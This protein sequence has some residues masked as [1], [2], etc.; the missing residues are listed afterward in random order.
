MLKYSLNVPKNII[1]QTLQETCIH[2][3]IIS[4]YLLEKVHSNCARRDK[5]KK[6]GQ[7][8]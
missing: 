4:L 2:R 5:I 1:L 3:L 7:E 6:T 8:S